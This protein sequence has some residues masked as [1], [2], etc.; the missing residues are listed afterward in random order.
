MYMYG[1]QG[2]IVSWG[3]IQ[4]SRRSQV[5]FLMTLFGVDSA[6]NEVGNRNLPGGKGCPLYKAGTLTTICEL[7]VYKIW[8]PQHFTNLWA[9]TP[10]TQLP[11]SLRLEATCVSETLET[12]PASTQSIEHSQLFPFWLYYLPPPIAFSLICSSNNYVCPSVF[13][14]FLLHSIIQWSSSLAWRLL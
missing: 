6:S 11:Y 4:Q 14:K 5:R 13:P 12:V 10:S 2:S 8:E 1:A 3:T 9:S 7:N